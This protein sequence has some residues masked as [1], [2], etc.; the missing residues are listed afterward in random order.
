MRKVT[1]IEQNSQNIAYNNKPR[2]VAYCRVSTDSDEQL[3]SFSAQVEHYTDYINSNP[4]WSFAGVY[5][6]E[7]IS[8]T[9]KENRTELLR[10]LT[11]CENRK[12]DLV[13]T[14]SISRLAR[15]TTDCLE[16]VRRLVSLGIGI[17]F[18]KE[19]I[20]TLNSEGELMLSIL[21]SFAAEE[22]SSISQ[23]VKWSIKKRFDNG[24]FKL[25]VPPYGYDYNGET[26]VIKTEQAEI[27]KRIFKEALNG[28][29]SRA[30]ATGLNK[31]DISPLRS[32]KWTSST[33]LGMLVN[34]KYIGDAIFQKTYSDDN[35]RRFRNYG[36]QN[37]Y[38][39]KDNHE[40]II[41]REDFEAV[42]VNI[43]QRALEKGNTGEKGK[44][45][46]QYTF[47]GRII[48]GECGGKFK[49]RVNMKNKGEQ[50]IAWCCSTHLNSNG[51]ECSMLFI[52][53]EHIKTAFVTMMT[54]LW[55]YKN[56][57]L[58]PLLSGLKELETLEQGS[59]ITVINKSIQ[60]LSE[61]VQ[62]LTSLLAKE[63]LEPALFNE[64]NNKLQSEIEILKDRRVTI[65]HSKD[66]GNNA[67]TR[68]EELLK[69]LH[70]ASKS[71]TEFDDELFLRFVET[72]TV[73]SPTEIGFN[74]KNGLCLR[75]QIT[76]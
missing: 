18:E 7:G 2:V 64:R 1:K 63:Y 53:D 10:L 58:K 20:N 11:D 28:H 59:E 45:H 26:L 54:K 3:A 39:V 34:E 38:Y 66:I 25:S 5:A 42:A 14:K 48:C 47:S 36:E 49:R 75:E 12:I 6:D 62:V 71:I 24:E 19:N 46:S 68:T 55:L 74:L 35:Y 31:D 43:T 4:E 65:Q 30:I 21:S 51:R 61:Q 72:I 16:I 33:I 50:Y 57:I 15:N 69:Y 52:R 29:G 67:I 17:F 22:S 70:K 44:Y 60:E 41:S 8:G 40:A 56:Q 13:I 32:E 27:V 37:Q 76:R 23:N 9:K 73:F